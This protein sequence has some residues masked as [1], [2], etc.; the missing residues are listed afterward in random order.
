MPWWHGRC[1][2]WLEMAQSR[3]LIDPVLLG[4]DPF[5]QAQDKRQIQAQN[6]DLTIPSERFWI[7]WGLQVILPGAVAIEDEDTLGV[8]PDHEALIEGL[9]RSPE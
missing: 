8:A 3:G 4:L 6:G 5:G 9:N 1:L 2:N 7:H